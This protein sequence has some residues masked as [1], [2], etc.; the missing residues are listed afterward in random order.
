MERNMRHNDF[1]VQHPQPIIIDEN[2]NDKIPNTE[3]SIGFCILTHEIYIT[4]E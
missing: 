3:I 2:L 4:G 1:E